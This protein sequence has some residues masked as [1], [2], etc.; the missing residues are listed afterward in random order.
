MCDNNSANEVVAHIA[1]CVLSRVVMKAKNP[2]S[3]EYSQILIHT[4]EIFFFV[5]LPLYHSGLQTAIINHRQTNNCHEGAVLA[6][7][8]MTRAVLS[9]H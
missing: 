4:A 6:R 1:R 3:V 8:D 9:G 5:R 7:D 2:N